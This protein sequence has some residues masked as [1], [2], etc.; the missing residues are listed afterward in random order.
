MTKISCVLNHFRSRVSAEVEQ[1][2]L[3]AKLWC[4]SCAHNTSRA[5]GLVSRT[6]REFKN[7]VTAVDHLSSFVTDINDLMTASRLPFNPTKTQVMWLGSKPAA[8]GQDCHKRHAAVA[9]PCNGR[10]YSSRPRRYSYLLTYSNLVTLKSIAK[11]HSRLNRWIDHTRLTII[12]VIW[13]CI[14]SWP[15]NVG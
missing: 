15:W 6:K 1:L 5:C 9:K 3:L 8:A 10:R 7:A 11:D 2:C 12:R 4:I 14:L 13:R